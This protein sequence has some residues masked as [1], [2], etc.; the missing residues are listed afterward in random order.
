MMLSVAI[1]GFIKILKLK[2]LKPLIIWTLKNLPILGPIVTLFLM[3]HDDL[4]LLLSPFLL[5][6]FGTL[7]VS[8]T[9][10]SDNEK[11]RIQVGGLTVGNL[12]TIWILVSI[13]LFYAFGIFS[14]N[15]SNANIGSIALTQTNMAIIVSFILLFQFII[16][17]G[18]QRKPGD[19][20]TK[21][22]MLRWFFYFI[23]STFSIMLWAYP[24]L[25][26]FGFDFPGLHSLYIFVLLSPFMGFYVFS[27][28]YIL[29]I[30]GAMARDDEENTKQ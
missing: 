29:C 18:I 13:I 30:K 6:L 8:L 23:Y 9:F 5:P 24:A 15:Y 21:L 20:F 26:L 14:N 19:F 10:A 25:G 4:L 2:F 11:G 17:I 12:A 28:I 1:G 22:T 16:V 7:A 3:F 27:H